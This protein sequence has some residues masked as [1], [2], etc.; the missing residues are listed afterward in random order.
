VTGARSKG[1][2]EELVEF[3]RPGRVAKGQDQHKWRV[4]EP[5][6]QRAYGEQG[7]AVRPVEVLQHQQ[8][9]RLAAR[10]F[11]QVDDVFY[12]LVTEI[13]LG[14]TAG[15]EAFGIASQQQRDGGATG[16]RRT[17]AEVEGVHHHA[18]RARPLEGMALAP[19]GG[20]AGGARL[21]DHPLHEA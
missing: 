7:R 6:H 21:V 10:L 5:L 1:L 8:H 13:L 11:H 19:Q 4:Y 18:E 17:P 16:I 15:S 14:P 20:D 2:V 3:G 9:G 12:D